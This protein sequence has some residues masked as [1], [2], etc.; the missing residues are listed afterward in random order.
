MSMLS[1]NHFYEEKKFF[2]EISFLGQK[3]KNWPKTNS[4][5]IIAR[6]RQIPNPLPVF[7]NNIAFGFKK[8]FLKYFEQKFTI[9]ERFEDHSENL[10]KYHFWVN[11][12]IFDPKMRFQKKNFFP[13][14]NGYSS[15]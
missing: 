15:T 7:E 4:T 2:F 6:N 11:F 14:K 5:E 13:H 12:S 8:T 3:L 10:Q 1:Y 9:L